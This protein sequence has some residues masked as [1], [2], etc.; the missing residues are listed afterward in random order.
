MMAHAQ[1]QPKQPEPETPD[2]LDQLADLLEETET[3]VERIQ[4][5]SPKKVDTE[6]LMLELKDTVMS[7]LLDSQRHIFDAIVDIRDGMDEFNDEL[8]KLGDRGPEA[9]TDS[10]LT[11]EDTEM[12][13]TLLVALKSIVEQSLEAAKAAGE[14][15]A[16]EQTQEMLARVDRALERL[17]EIREQD[18]EESESDEP[19]KANGKSE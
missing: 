14:E 1:P 7:I 18:S 2:P 11:A 5:L 19:A 9:P 15:E 8:D 16:Q 12:F 4:G 6:A 13:G 3:H 10:F 17:E